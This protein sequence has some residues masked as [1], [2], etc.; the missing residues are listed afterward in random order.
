MCKGDEEAFQRTAMDPRMKDLSKQLVLQ[1]SKKG[2]LL[3]VLMHGKRNGLIALLYGPP[4][5]GKTLT[6]K[7]LATLSGKPLYPVTMS[8]AGTSSAAV[9]NNMNKIFQLATQWEA[10][11]LFDEADIFLEK[12]SLRDLERNSLVSVLLRILE[13]FSG[14]LFLTTNRVKTFDEAFQSRI[15]VA[16]QYK[17]LNDK[18]KGRIWD[19]WLDKYHDKVQDPAAIDE[20]V[21]NGEWLHAELNGRQIRNMFSRDM[22]LAGHDNYGMIN[23]S[24]IKR[25]M[26][27][28]FQFQMYMDQARKQAE[29]EGLR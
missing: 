26:K 23:E 13:Y 20:E 24:H 5:V 28:T 15:H 4:G 21:T 7:A 25:V 17:E 14:I 18:Q 8:D 22:A 12:R 2:S 6:A 19:Y 9:E 16:V 27:Q 29:T 11:L 1:H 3:A 10:L